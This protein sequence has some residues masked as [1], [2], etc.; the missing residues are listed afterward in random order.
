MSL[1]LLNNFPHPSSG[2]LCWQ[3]EEVCLWSTLAFQISKPRPLL[4]ATCL[5]EW[6]A[7]VISLLLLA[8]FSTWQ[9]REVE[10]T[11]VA[12][13]KSGLDQLCW[14][15]GVPFCSNKRGNPRPSL[16]LG[17]L[18]SFSCVHLKYQGSSLDGILLTTKDLNGLFL[19]WAWYNFWDHL[20][21]YSVSSDWW[22]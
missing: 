2:C 11:W 13:G 9:H 12:Q 15:S 8:S 6:P 7:Q 14:C 19:T 20:L 4:R 22:G 17:N 5:E 16:P 1:S 3:W 21:T 18:R 10:A